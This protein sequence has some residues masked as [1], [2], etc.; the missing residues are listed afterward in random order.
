MIV[1]PKWTADIQEDG[2]QLK[3][4]VDAMLEMIPDGSM[5]LQTFKDQIEQEFT[6]FQPTT[7]AKQAEEV[8]KTEAEKGSNAQDASAETTSASPHKG[9][10]GKVTAEEHEQ[11]D[12][13]AELLGGLAVSKTAAKEPVR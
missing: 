5:D 3:R 13:L 6:G 8:S 1:L 11:Q 9:A 10:K 2:S 7:G 4:L 12:A